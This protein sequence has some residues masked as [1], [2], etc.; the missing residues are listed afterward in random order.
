MNGKT[1]CAVFAIYAA[2]LTP[3]HADESPRFEFKGIYPGLKTES[4]SDDW[5]CEHKK[6]SFSDTI[7]SSIK[8]SGETIAGAKTK[9]VLILATNYT[10]EQVVVVFDSK[11]YLRIK[12]ALIEKYGN[13]EVLNFE[14][15]NRM[16]AKFDNQTVTWRDNSTEMELRKLA[17]KVDQGNLTIKYTDW[18]QRGKQRI[19]ND[20]KIDAGD[21]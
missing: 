10:T 8:R 19:S 18:L 12:T 16:G 6:T 3:S 9:Q 11:D 13:G 4:L 5:R 2:A 15:A 7:C 21:L 17:S 14:V 1:I 20:S